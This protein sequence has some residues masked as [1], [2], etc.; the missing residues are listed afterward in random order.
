[1]AV[2]VG[3]GRIEYVARFD[4]GVIENELMKLDT[5]VWY[6]ARRMVAGYKPSTCESACYEIREIAISCIAI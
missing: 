4:N 3:Y 6:R 2:S 5:R 1:M